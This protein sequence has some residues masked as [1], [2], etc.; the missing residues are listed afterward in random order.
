M[1][2]NPC[3]PAGRS[4]VG[5]VRVVVQSAPMS[6]EKPSGFRPVEDYVLNKIEIEEE[7]IQWLKTLSPG[8][9]IVMYFKSLFL[10]PSEIEHHTGLTRKSINQFTIKAFKK[11]EAE[12]PDVVKGRFTI[13]PR[14]IRGKSTNN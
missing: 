4:E 9:L 7:I 14:G 6:P 1:N 3:L 2:N 12:I 10:S 11:A 5:K 13:K 8:E